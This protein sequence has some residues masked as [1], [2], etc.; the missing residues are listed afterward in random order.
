MISFSGS[1]ENK[2]QG[3]M[4]PHLFYQ[5]PGQGWAVFPGSMIFNASASA[6]QVTFAPNGTA[7][8]GQYLFSAYFDDVT[9]EAD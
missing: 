5:P 6:W 7:L 4:I 2:V 1:D 9:L 3:S 8:L